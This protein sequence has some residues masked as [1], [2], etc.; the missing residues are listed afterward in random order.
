V[1]ELDDTRLVTYASDK[2]LA[3]ICFDLVDVVASTPISVGI[4]TI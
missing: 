3:D 2:A 4:V 1:R